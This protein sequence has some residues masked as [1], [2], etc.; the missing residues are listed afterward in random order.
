[1]TCQISEPRNHSAP[2]KTVPNSTPKRTS[3]ALMGGRSRRG[4]TLSRSTSLSLRQRFLTA[5]LHQEQYLNIRP[6]SDIHQSSPSRSGAKFYL[7]KT[8]TRPEAVIALPRA[9]Q[10]G[11]GGDVYL[12]PSMHPEPAPRS[13]I[14]TS[15]DVSCDTIERGLPCQKPSSTMPSSAQVRT[16][17]Y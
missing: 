14:P 5:G 7:M 2:H 6:T 8:V 17:W 3:P 16:T 1:M 15:A 13:A 4:S 12:R 11:A 9:R 10:T